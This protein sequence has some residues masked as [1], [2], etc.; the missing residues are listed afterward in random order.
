MNKQNGDSDETHEQWLA[1]LTEEIIEPEMPIVDAHHHLWIRE[2][3][4][5]LMPELLAD[6][7]SGH[8]VIATVFAECHAMYRARGP[9]EMCPVGETEFVTG[10]AAMSD[11]APYRSRI[12]AA[13]IIAVSEP[14]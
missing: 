2:G 4:S 1:R 3:T 14:Y 12:R 11:G 8:N 9:E 6:L 5:Y 7:Y 13:G 10:V